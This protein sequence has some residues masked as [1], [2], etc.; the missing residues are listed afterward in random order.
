M[1]ETW[2]DA[3]TKV[4]ELDVGRGNLVWSPRI[5]EKDEFPDVLAEIDRP[6][7][8]TFVR[9]TAMIYSAGGPCINLYTGFTEFHF[10][11]GLS[12]SARIYVYKFIG[13]IEIA[14]AAKAKLGGL[15]EHFLITGEGLP[16]VQGPVS[17]QYGEEAE[18]WGLV[19]NWE[20]K[21]RVD[22]QVVVAA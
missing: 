3:L 14:A 6:I 21:E 2:I 20:V 8:L 12:A 5:F 10:Q 15:V 13:K 16:S 4:W 11:G 22:S 19:V 9:S 7:A 18:H 17:L 1:I